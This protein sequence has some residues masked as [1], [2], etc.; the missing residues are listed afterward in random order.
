M[1]V[2]SVQVFGVV[3]D[4]LTG[5]CDVAGAFASAG[6]WAAVRFGPECHPGDI[7][8]LVS[9][10]DV[11]DAASSDLT[12]VRSRM[13]ASAKFLEKCGAEVQMLKIDSTLRGPIGP[14]VAS[15]LDRVGAP[16][17]IVA[18]ALPEQGR[19][20][21]GAQLVLSA[22]PVGDAVNAAEL[23]EDAGL[24]VG[25]IAAEVARTSAAKLEEA[26]MDQ[27][28]SGALAVIVDTDDAACLNSVAETWMRHPQLL[29]VGSLGVARHMAV[30]LRKK[31]AGRA[32]WIHSGAPPFPKRQGVL[33]ISGSPTPTTAA[34]LE[35]LADSSGCQV[36]ELGTQPA[37]NAFHDIDAEGVI[38]L[39]TPPPQAVHADGLLPIRDSGEQA[40]LLARAVAEM[41]E[42]VRPAGLVLNG[43]STARAVLE[44]L[45][46]QGVDVYGEVEAGIPYGIVSGGTWD[47]LPVATKAG[48]FGHPG[49]ILHA[50]TQLR[51]VVS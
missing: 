20:L 32:P 14:M 15:V 12:R 16:G 43:G 35:L 45:G 10:A 7:D 50:V 39:R 33:V 6:L 27:L 3:A 49:S 46:A 19:F 8:V 36:F 42:R 30:R 44:K 48:G 34:Q 23:L 1:I 29:L 26:I 28:F 41:A 4:D 13:L 38:C 17:A 51:E 21:S 9:D 25:V 22:Q 5:A 31:E 2:R 18:P 24:P 37:W 47:G 40:S 11:R